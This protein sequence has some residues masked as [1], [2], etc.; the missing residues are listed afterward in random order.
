M[1]VRKKEFLK[2]LHI[3]G[4]EIEDGYIKTQK[5]DVDRW[6]FYLS[7]YSK[8]IEDYSLP[9]LKEKANTNTTKLNLILKHLGLEYQDACREQLPKLRKIKKANI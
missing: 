6:S 1:F 8:C 3:L 5:K 4:L 2:L 7:I 9:H